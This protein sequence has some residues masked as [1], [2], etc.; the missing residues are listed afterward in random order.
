MNDKFVHQQALV[1]AQR[2]LEELPDAAPEERI[3]AMYLQAFSRGPEPAEVAAC[4]KALERFGSLEGTSGEPARWA[5][6]AHA[7]WNVKEFIYLP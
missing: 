7:L 2:V 3:Q 4:I 1:W 5:S 6:L